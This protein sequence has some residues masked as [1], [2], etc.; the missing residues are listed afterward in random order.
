[1]ATALKV[2]QVRSLLHKPEELRKVL[3]GM[4][5]GKT[6]K[7]VVLPDTPEVRGMI[8]KVPHLVKVERVD[9]SQRN[10]ARLRARKAAAAAKR[11]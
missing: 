4:G 3:R 5:L 8:Y 6:W 9:E 7:S 10:S 2:T 11:E 1:M